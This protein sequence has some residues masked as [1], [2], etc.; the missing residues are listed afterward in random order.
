MLDHN[1][2]PAA[3]QWIKRYI[4]SLDYCLSRYA[5]EYTFIQHPDDASMYNVF[6]IRRDE[7]GQYRIGSQRCENI[8]VIGVTETDLFVSVPCPLGTAPRVVKISLAECYEMKETVHQE[9]GYSR[10]SFIEGVDQ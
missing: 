4:H 7:Y 8:I 2:M 9:H 3:F 10:L 6:S 5:Y 1:K